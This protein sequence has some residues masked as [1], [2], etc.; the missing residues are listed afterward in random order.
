MPASP[1]SRAV[2]PRMTPWT[3]RSWA[4]PQTPFFTALTLRTVSPSVD[5]ENT[6]VRVNPVTVRSATVT[7]LTF[8]SF[9]PITQMPLPPS[10]HVLSVAFSV[11][12]SMTVP[13]PTPRR[14]S[15]GVL[16][17]TLSR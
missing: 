4:M 11:P 13:R 15:P 17:L 16:T 9:V 2:L 10:A 14:V 6:P 8:L 1:L 7:P 5:I 12:G 3:D